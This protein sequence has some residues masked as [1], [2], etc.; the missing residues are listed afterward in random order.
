MSVCARAFKTY[1]SAQCIFFNRLFRRMIK[2]GHFVIRSEF[3]LYFMNRMNV[4]N[5][6]A[7]VQEELCVLLLL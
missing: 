2:R 7:C 1:Q 4:V 5:V 6:I 3:F